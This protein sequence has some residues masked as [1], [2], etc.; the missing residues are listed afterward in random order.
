MPNVKIFVDE[1]HY[2]AIRGG[3]AALLPDLRV[4]LCS[5]L[6]VDETAFQVAVIPVLGIAGQPPVNIEMQLMP[7]PERTRE[8]VGEIAAQLRAQLGKALDQHVAVRITIID[9]DKYV[10]LK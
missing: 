1:T 7:R 8:A 5:S 6:L 4:R 2:S 10:T 3:I 9:A